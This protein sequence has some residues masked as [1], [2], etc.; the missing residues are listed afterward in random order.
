MEENC[1]NFEAQ[2]QDLVQ[3][4][5]KCSELEAG[6][7]DLTQNMPRAETGLPG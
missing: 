3:V 6:V 7:R 1:R 2:S 5:A 4:R